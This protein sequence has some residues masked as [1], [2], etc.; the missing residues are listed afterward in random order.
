MLR[1]AVEAYLELFGKIKTSDSLR[2]LDA[3]GLFWK[4]S[5]ETKK[6]KVKDEPNLP[7][8]TSDSE[9]E[10][11]DLGP[12]S[13]ADEAYAD[14]KD[15]AEIEVVS[16]TEKTKRSCPPIPY[17][18]RSLQSDAM[19]LLG[20]GPEEIA[21]ISQKMYE[22]GITSYYRS[23]WTGYTESSHENV[24]SLVSDAGLRVEKR[25]YQLPPE[26]GHD[27]IH[28]IYSKKI[29]LGEDGL[30]FPEAWSNPG[31]A[32][33]K[34]R[35]LFDLIHRRT[36]ASMMPDFVSKE[37]VVVGTVNG[38][39]F[40]VRTNVVVD[41]GFSEAFHW[42]LS[43]VPN[44]VG[45]ETAAGYSKGENLGIKDRKL[46]KGKFKF[47]SNITVSSFGKKLEKLRIG[48]PAT[49]VPIY[50]LIQTKGYVRQT[51]DLK[52]KVLAK[53][54]VLYSLTKSYDV[55]DIELTEKM[56]GGLEDV[57]T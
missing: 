13:D 26:A 48:T 52:I 55:F 3:N 53:G 35:R 7:S 18:D 9:D 29:F 36:L 2:L 51:D 30:Y 40:E 32:P 44:S 56:E 41:A 50:K 4:Y 20:M 28:T 39:R 5:P 57:E 33:H 14:V 22:Q 54:F 25:R 37:R 47:S 31:A 45:P 15:S 24:A 49:S 23:K 43:G 38:R 11:G 12:G 42:F 16:V 21:D 10:E 46:E 17:N 34:Y 19:N 8:E 6:G 1:L 27:G